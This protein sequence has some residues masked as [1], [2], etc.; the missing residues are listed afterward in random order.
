MLATFTPNNYV[1]L[2][3]I[4]KDIAHLEC[5]VFPVKFIPRFAL[6]GGVISVQLAGLLSV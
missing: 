3:V 6:T 1:E 4:R 2:L 5:T